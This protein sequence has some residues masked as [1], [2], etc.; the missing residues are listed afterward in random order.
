[1]SRDP[2]RLAA[3]LLFSLVI[4]STLLAVPTRSHGQ[5]PPDVTPDVTPGGAA[6]LADLR[7]RDLAR[8]DLAGVDLALAN[9]TDADLTQADLTG[10]RLEATTLTG[11]DLSGAVLTGADLSLADLRDATLRDADLRNAVLTTADLR[12]AD[13]RNADLTGAVLNNANLD[14]AQLDG[15]V[16]AGTSY[17]AHTVWPPGFDPAAQAL[18]PAAPATPPLRLEMSI[19]P[20][21]LS[22][23]NRVAGPSDIARVDHPRDIA[24]L[25]GVTSGQRMAVF[26]SAALAAQL[27]PRIAGQVEIIGYNIEH[28]P[29]NPLDEQADPVAAAQALRRVLDPLGLKLAIGPDHDFA[30]SHGVALA[31]LADQFVLQIQRVQ[32]QPGVAADFVDGMATALRAANPD[33]E[34]SVQVRT[35]GD[36]AQVAALI[37]TL[38]DEIDGVAV[39]T[40]PDGVDEAESMVAAIRPE[41]ASRPPDAAPVADAPVRDA[42]RPRWGALFLGLGLELFL[43]VALVAAI[44]F[45][46][47]SVAVTRQ[48]R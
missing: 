39:L 16:L 42:T 23:Y 18:E 34:I 32:E 24:L 27:A 4:I 1:M 8:A 2:I 20:P 46:G 22:L 47:A 28:G 48:R 45:I 33:L 29:L 21:L 13:L 37:D 9:L 19:S 44:I 41:A 43:L 14:G 31:P 11:A 25:A 12:R 40:R 3:K 30:L 26:K 38:A 7:G 17:D 6:V 15:V 35:D 36:P 5:T 10:A